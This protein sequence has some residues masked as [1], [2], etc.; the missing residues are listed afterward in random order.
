MKPSI[1]PAIAAPTRAKKIGGPILATSYA[2][3]KA[4]VAGAVRAAILE[5]ASQREVARV[6]GVSHRLVQAWCADDASN[7]L[8]L[9]VALAIAE[10]GG[11]SCRA[12]VVDTLRAV[13]E[14]AE[15]GLRDT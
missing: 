6:A 4:V 15:R 5:H 10:D 9:D 1:V 11:P 14:M 3:A 7:G 13:L 2:R 12:V 8:R